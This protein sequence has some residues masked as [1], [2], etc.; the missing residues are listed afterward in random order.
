MGL[1]RKIDCEKEEA[2]PGK[3]VIKEGGNV[4]VDHPIYKKSQQKDKFNKQKTVDHLQKRPAK[5]TGNH[6]AILD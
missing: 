6:N 1:S 4:Q 2:P 3:M 5:I